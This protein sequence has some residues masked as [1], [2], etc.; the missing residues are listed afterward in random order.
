MKLA[1][2][3]EF[4]LGRLRVRPAE[5][6]LVGPDGEQVIEPRVMEVL[7]L[8]ARTPGRVI[9]RD[10]LVE[11]CWDGRI[12]GEDAI[13]RVISRIRRLSEAS[14]GADFT[15]ETIPRVGYR[16]RVTPQPA[17]P[18]A[19]TRAESHPR[20][21][22]SPDVAMPQ[23]PAEDVARAMPPVQTLAGGPAMGASGAP[24]GPAPPSLPRPATRPRR[25]PMAWAGAGVAVIALVVAAAVTL[26]PRQSAPAA[27]APPTTTLAVLPFEDFTGADDL[28]Y[29]VEGLPRQLRN[30]V[31]RIH[32]L[33]VI[34][35]TS[36]LSSDAREAAPANA[37]RLL[38][39]NVLLDGSVNRTP[40][41]ISVTV[42]M[43]EPQSRAIVWTT[44][45]SGTPDDPGAIEARLS[46][47]VVEQI[48][49][50]YGD[51]SLSAPPVE[52]PVD[53]V[54][55]RH[56][57]LA[58]QALRDAQTPAF[59]GQQDRSRALRLKAAEH[60]RLALER[61]PSNSDAVVGWAQHLLLDSPPD[62][63]VET[64]T[65]RRVEGE[66]L[67]REAI[68]L[69]PNNPSA[70]TALAE[71]YRRVEWRWNDAQRLF[72]RSLTIDPNAVYTHTWF[73]Y[74]LSTT[75]RCRDALEHA[76]LAGRLDPLNTWRKLAEARILKCLGR[77]DLASAHYLEALRVDRANLFLIREV[78]LH[79]ALLRDASALRMSSD[80]IERDLWGGAPT[81]PVRRMVD[82]GSLIADAL[83]GRGDP[84]MQLVEA[85]AARLAA[86]PA[87]WDQGRR[88]SDQWWTLA[89]EA[90]AAGRTERA[91]DLLE[92]A[93]KGGSL[94][95]PESLPHGM[96][97]F[98]PEIRANP[99]YRALWRTTRGWS[100]W[101]ACAG[102]R[103][104]MARWP[105]STPMAA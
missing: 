84:L 32:G 71:H 100:N 46:S 36:S 62:S 40:G 93:M 69:D 1:S 102:R 21:F 75:G 58:Y 37:A 19:P 91:I 26:A 11:A 27:S 4:S 45:V 89:I 92:T 94:Y 66:R 16:L 73:T 97:E 51:Q 57:L 29:V 98:T 63:R 35:D 7:A 30:R 13:T 88:R 67:L 49:I 64:A 15:I 103:C 56:V 8:M 18:E 14:D 61:D 80:T 50:R 60:F 39:A 10:E 87:G 41:G 81:E 74:Q 9:G 86:A 83:D 12:V 78:Q 38:G 47:A 33:N 72:E 34:A 22:P 43:I 55:H 42:E 96:L 95:I 79:W 24:P 77:H 85:D 20:S 5:R 101:P 76:R 31:A 54:S 68:R 52:A 90:A 3:P 23:A 99:R 44:E 70:L 82:R 2:E 59:S 6:M 104:G 28:G 17:E 65:E 105:A 53:P 25:W 48:L